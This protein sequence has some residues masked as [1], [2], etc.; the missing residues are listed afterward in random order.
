[1]KYFVTLLLLV[2]FAN[3]S[4]AQLT[5]TGDEMLASLGSPAGNQVSYNDST[6]LSG[7]TPLITKTGASQ[8]WDFSNQPWVLSTPTVTGTSTTLVYPGGAP[9]ANDPDFT[10]S[11]HVIKTVYSDPKLA[12]NY[13]FF[14]LD[15]TGIW[16]LGVSQDSFGIKS[17]LFSYT[18]P[19]QEYKFP[20]TYQTT[21]QSTSNFNIPN[22]PPGY[23][24]TISDDDIVDAYGT[25]ITPYA[26]HKKNGATPL[27]SNECLRVKNKITSATSFMGFKTSTSTYTYSW[28]TKNNHTAVIVADQNQIPKSATYAIS[29]GST[30]VEG[31]N[32]GDNPLNVRISAN[33]ISNRETKLSYTIKNGSNAQV[34]LMDQ[35]GREVHM[36]QN[37]PAQSGENI[38]PLDPTTLASGTYFIRI[39]ADGFTA[40]RKLII[41][42]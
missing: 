24:T 2:L 11:T 42:K 40:I 30:S 7:L 33:P 9:F 5:F 27:A 16:L 4:S 13:K 23:T 18:P 12:T 10:A 14:K 28:I 17:K 8:T 39:K 25:L 19:Y 38:I 1:M 41:T 32:V 34:T 37:G 21:W 6:Q 36:L 29:Q 3:S 15:Q 22:L 35:L 20:M 31:L 26:A